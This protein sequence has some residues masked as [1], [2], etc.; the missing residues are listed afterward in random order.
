MAALGLIGARE[1]HAK[2]LW[3]SADGAW[4]LDLGGHYKAYVSGLALPGGLVDGTTALSR[5]LDAAKLQ[6]PEEQ[7][8]LVPGFDPL[9]REAAMST[10]VARIQGRLLWTSHLDFEAAW[11]VGIA[12]ASHPGFLQGSSL[13]GSPVGS[14]SAA[15]RRLVD[16][17]PVL[18]QNDVFRVQHDLDRL[19]LKLSLPH[20][21]LVVGRQVL[22]W[23]SG[24]LWNPT[25]LLSPFAPTDIDKEIRKGVD[26]VRLSFQLGSTGL[27]DLMWLPQQRPEDHGGVL[28]GQ[29]NFGGYDVSLSAAKYVSDVVFGADVSGDAGPLGVH[30][31]AAY[32]LGITGWSTGDLK[33]DEH[34]FRGVAGAEWRPHE[35]LILMAEYYFNGF[36]ATHASGY[37]A[38]MQSDRV[39]RGE[40]FG[41]GRHYLGLVASWLATDLLTANLTVLGNLQDPSAMLVPVIEYSVEQSVLLRLG[42]FVPI[43]KGPDPRALQALE[44]GDVLAQTAAFKAATS[45]LGLRSEYGTSAAGVFLQ[46]AVYR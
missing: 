5:T 34:F 30:V 44:P 19:A 11:Q 29:L 12:M 21:D 36:G 31:E 7:A 16:F 42:G 27:L 17:D 32:T 13:G 6:L 3:K 39:A 40:I 22:S 1:A 18:G 25:D 46:V 15:Q 33:V 38:K 23:G 37:L 9:P 26:A 4:E 35:K 43:G 41:A 8:A 20:V 45:T 10:H 28:R 14:A 2:E 24:R